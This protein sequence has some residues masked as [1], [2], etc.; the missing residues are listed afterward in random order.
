MLVTL[1][2]RTELD[3]LWQLLFGWR[4]FRELFHVATN[5]HHLLAVACESWRC[6]IQLVTVSPKLGKLCRHSYQPSMVAIAANEPSLSA[7][8]RLPSAIHS[9]P[10]SKRRGDLNVKLIFNTITIFLTPLLDL[11]AAFS[12]SFSCCCCYYSRTY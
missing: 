9:P 12:A 5:N 8:C 6:P 2:Q 3:R 7:K 11:L 1:W 4:P 10:P